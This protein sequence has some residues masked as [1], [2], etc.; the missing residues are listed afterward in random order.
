ML[1]LLSSC[2]DEGV[3]SISTIIPVLTFARI[4]GFLGDFPL[5]YLSI[6]LDGELVLDL[7]VGIRDF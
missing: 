4:D 7:L 1:A 5:L 6:G 3:S 2:F